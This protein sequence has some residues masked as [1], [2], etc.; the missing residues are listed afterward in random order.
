MIFW[1]IWFLGVAATFAIGETWA[2]RTKRPTLSRYM[3]MLAT[4]WPLLMV[5]YGM[6]FGGLAVHFFWRWNVPGLPTFGG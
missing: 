5:V 4:E 6:L 2:I 1:T 3:A